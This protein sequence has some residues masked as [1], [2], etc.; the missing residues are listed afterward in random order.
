[1]GSMRETEVGRAET[2]DGRARANSHFPSHPTRSLSLSLSRL[3]EQQ[4]LT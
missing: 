1:M 2:D 3:S 4:G